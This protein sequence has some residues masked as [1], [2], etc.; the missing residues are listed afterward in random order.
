[1]KQLR[2]PTTYFFEQAE[3]LTDPYKEEIEKFVSKLID[4]D[5]CQLC[6][7]DYDLFERIPRIM[8][9]CGHTFC[10]PCLTEF[11]MY[12]R[13][14]SSNKRVRCPMCLKLVKY[15]DTL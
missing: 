15:L 6:R 7:N 1:M 3:N 4:K 14:L 10:T 8:I 5:K 9:H 12:H 13:P 2:N 11:Y